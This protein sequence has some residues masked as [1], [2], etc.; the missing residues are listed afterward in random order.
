[1]RK[2]ILP[3]DYPEIRKNEMKTYLIEG[4]DKV[5][6]SMS[7]QA[8]EDGEKE[9]KKMGVTLLLNKRVSNYENDTVSME[10]G[11]TIATKTVIWV[12]GVTSVHFDGIDPQLL[13]KGGCI[14]VNAYNQVGDYL[15]VFA[16][17]NIAVIADKDNPR[18]HPQLAQPAIQQGNL[19]AK[20][21]KRIEKGEELEPFHYKDLGTLATIGRNKAVADIHQLKFH[22]FFAWLIWLFVHLRSNLGVKNKMFTLLDWMW[23][24]VTY[25]QSIRLI[26]SAPC[27]D[28]EVNREEEHEPQA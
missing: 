22:G 17:G 12:S 16:I 27:P 9:L 28:D 19:L 6:A 3:K 2:Y 5:L 4:E 15:N 13:N 25:D 14:N 7:P 8:S 21:L 23:S 24:Y 18:G 1:M 20:N 26:L 11:E 10:S